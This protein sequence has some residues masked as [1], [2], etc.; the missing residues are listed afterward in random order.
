MPAHRETIKGKSS[1][2]HMEVQVQED[3]IQCYN[4]K[5]TTNTI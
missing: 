5:N 1:E 2:D 3:Y 4:I